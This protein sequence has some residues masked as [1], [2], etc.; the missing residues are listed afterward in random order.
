M[1]LTAATRKSVTDLT[2]RKTRA[3]MTVL[4]L[5]IAV[6]SVGI[7]AVPSLMQQAMDRQ[8]ASTHLADLTVSFNPLVITDRQL[9]ALARTPNVVAVQP[10]TVLST[11]VYVGSRRQKAV[12]IGVPDYARQNTDVV[13]IKSG[14]PPAGG[15]LLTDN[16][17][18]SKNKFH[19]GRGETVRV[20]AAGGRVRPVR[21]SGTG[22]YLGG[23]Q[24]VA[25]GGLRG[26]LRHLADGQRPERRPRLHDAGDAP[27]RPEPGSRRAHRQGGPERAALG[28]GLHRLR[29]L[30]GDP[31]AR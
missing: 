5:A 19:G 28:E 23:S 17:N 11:R 4:T 13:A 12:I 10:K 14:A 22:Q 9:R 21:I 18:A 29:R 16:Q 30:P 27:A 7:F 15:T 31:H 25:E 1:T 3:V 8:I 20:I 24:L 6:A 26:L 2:R